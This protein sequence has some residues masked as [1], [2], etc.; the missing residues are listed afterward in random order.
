MI[1]RTTIAA[2]S[3]VLETLRDEAARRGLSLARL[4]GEILA[5]KA[6]ALR[7]ERR[8]RFGLGRSGGGVA[9]ASVDDEESP[10]R[11]A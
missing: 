5:E 1:Q 9:Q 6:A 7:A 8:P 10:A 2:E 4:V 11:G 3:D